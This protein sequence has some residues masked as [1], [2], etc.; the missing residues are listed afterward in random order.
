MKPIY[1]ED[2]ITNKLYEILCDSH[3]RTIGRGKDC[4]IITNA[5]YS[6]ISRLQ[7]EVIYL[8]N[9]IRL[10]QRSENSKTLVGNEEKGYDEVFQGTDARLYPGHSIIMGK[11]YMFRVWFYN[12][13]KERLTKERIARSEDTKIVKSDEIIN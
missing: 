3:P 6:D 7:A 9:E 1:L 8:P 4:D 12:E 13:I 5:D 2:L 11:D 10:I